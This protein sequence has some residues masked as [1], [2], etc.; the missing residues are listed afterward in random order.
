MA[1]LTP[2]QIRDQAH[3]DS[4]RTRLEQGLPAQVGPDNPD[5][6]ARVVGVL[7]QGFEDDACRRAKEQTA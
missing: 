2:E 4:A 5:E 1:A 3:A 7:R 6:L